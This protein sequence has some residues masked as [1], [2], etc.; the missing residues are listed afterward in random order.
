VPRA[1]NF[2]PDD[3]KAQAW[4]R[5]NRDLDVNGDERFRDLFDRFMPDY[6]D[7]YPH[8]SGAWDDMVDAFEELDRYLK[9]EY[10]DEYDLIYW[11]DEDDWR[12]NYAQEAM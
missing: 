8:G 10:G 9:Q 7:D 1:H 6:K 2:Y 12:A 5:I 4:E 11:C 3:G